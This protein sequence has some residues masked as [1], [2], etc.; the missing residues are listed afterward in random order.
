MYVCYLWKL[1]GIP[2]VFDFNYCISAWY[3]VANYLMPL[4]MRY[5]GMCVVM[6]TAH[7]Y[8]CQ[9]ICQRVLLHVA[10]MLFSSLHTYTHILKTHNIT[11]R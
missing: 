5:V 6:L 3:A 7:D 4:H 2:V 1:R 8:C 11:K 10:N 9:M